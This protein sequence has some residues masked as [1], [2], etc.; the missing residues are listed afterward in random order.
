[1]SKVKIS[2][3]SLKI[4]EKFIVLNLD[5]A[6]ELQQ[7]L[8]DTFGKQETVYIPSPPIY[9][10]RE[11]PYPYKY[12]EPYITYDTKT[13]NTGDITFTFTETKES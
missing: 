10:E 7:L 2:K 5:E 4:G 3:I 6:K 8:N 13:A 9:I 11:W 12:W 1:M